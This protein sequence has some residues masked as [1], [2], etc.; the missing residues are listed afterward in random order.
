MSH[1]KRNDFLLQF[2]LFASSI[3][4]GKQILSMYIWTTYLTLQIPVVILHVIAFEIR[5]FHILLADCF[6]FY[7]DLRTNSDYFPIQN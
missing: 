3:N 6:V 7:V 4:W 2:N 5:K 1:L